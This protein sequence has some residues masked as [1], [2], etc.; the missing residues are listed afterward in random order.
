[1][2]LNIHLE[3]NQNIKIG[4]IQFQKM[5]FIFNAINDGWII[6][7]EDDSYVFTKPHHN[8]K[9]IYRDDYLSLFIKNNF[10]TDNL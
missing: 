2:D 4:H 8:K 1:M 3:Q 7:K 10:N 9:E 6:K 5:L